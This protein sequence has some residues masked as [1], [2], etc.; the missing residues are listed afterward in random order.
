M[1]KPDVS[2]GLLPVAHTLLSVSKVTAIDASEGQLKHATPHPKV[3]YRLGL[4]EETGVPDHS[5]DLVASAQ[6]MHW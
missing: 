4:A 2:A 3:E 6:A 1:V 5:L